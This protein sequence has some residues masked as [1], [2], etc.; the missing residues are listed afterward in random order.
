MRIRTYLLFFLIVAFSAMA[1]ETAAPE[2]APFPLEE[3][4]KEETSFTMQLLHM[5]ATLGLL[6]SLVL[7]ASWF[8]KKMMQTRVKQVNQSS[9]IKILEQRPLTHKTVISLIEIHGK[10]IAIAESTN[11]VTLLYQLASQKNGEIL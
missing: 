3:N 10:E 6:I 7:L 2:T 9:A 1:A 5:L 4:P 11:G 8:L